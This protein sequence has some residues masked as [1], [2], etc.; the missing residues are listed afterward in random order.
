M[1]CLVT[2]LKGSVDDNSLPFLGEAII[3]Y[4]TGI[5]SVRLNPIAGETVPVRIIGDG[6]FTNSTGGTNLGKEILL[7]N[8]EGGN[9]LYLS[10]SVTK[11]GIRNRD[12]LLSLT[13][14]EKVLS[15]LSVL[16]YMTE[17]TYVYFYGYG[18]ANAIKG[19]LPKITVNWSFGDKTMMNTETLVRIFPNLGGLIT[20]GRVGY[21][22]GALSNI[23]NKYSYMSSLNISNS[24]IVGNVSDFASMPRI[25][26]IG[27]YGCKSIIG[28]IDTL[29]TIATLTRLSIGNSSVTG[30]DASKL[31]P[32][33]DQIKTEQLNVVF[34]WKTTRPSSAYIIATNGTNFGDDLDAFLINQ[35]NCTANHASHTGDAAYAT[36]HANGTRT[37]ASNSAIATLRGKGYTVTVPNAQ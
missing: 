17:L 27:I 35:A 13:M 19:S 22:D 4:E 30:G 31:P 26:D 21:I 33:V 28:N 15:P 32:L 1:D 14:T 2:K 5:K 18:D 8:V 6:N 9:L 10:D 37:S 29:S 23:T 7:N 25:K 16:S 34:S 24:K 3:E 11:I 36:I 12:K 20:N